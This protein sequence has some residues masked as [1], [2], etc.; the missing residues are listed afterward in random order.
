MTTPNELTLVEKPNLKL[1]GAQ[2]GEPAENTS[3]Q[4]LSGSSSG[5]SD[6]AGG[7]DGR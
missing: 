4:N 2:S 1:M 6:P 7:L 5:S 3:L